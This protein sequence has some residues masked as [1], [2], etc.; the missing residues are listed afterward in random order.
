MAIVLSTTFDLNNLAF[1]MLGI[2]FWFLEACDVIGWWRFYIFSD[3]SIGL[4]GFLFYD[5]FFL[6]QYFRLMYAGG[7]GQFYLEWGLHHFLPGIKI[8]FN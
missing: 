7:G 2:Y 3:H 8:L 1:H 6:P 5:S 4:W